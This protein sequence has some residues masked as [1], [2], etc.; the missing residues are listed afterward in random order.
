MI[1]ITDK[2]QSEIKNIIKQEGKKTPI[3]HIGVKNNGCSGISYF[4]GLQDNI[5]EQEYVFDINGIQIYI[6]RASQDYLKGA[7][8]D[9]TKTDQGAGF[10]FKNPNATRSCDCGNSFC[11]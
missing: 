8:L 3:L 5:S 2:A 4:M 1:H 11:A 10:I 9:F 6:D 7:E